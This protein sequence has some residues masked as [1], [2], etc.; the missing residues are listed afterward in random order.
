MM[1]PYGVIFR[2]ERKYMHHKHPWRSKRRALMKVKRSQ[3]KTARQESDRDLA[4]ELEEYRR[5]S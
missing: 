5:A 2:I 4:F 3:R 1:K